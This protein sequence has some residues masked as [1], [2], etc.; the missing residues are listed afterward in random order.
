MQSVS[1]QRIGKHATTTIEVLLESVFYIP[2]VQNGHKED[3]VIHLVKAVQLSPASEAEKR[4][5]CS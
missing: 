5:R 2:S 3:R 1:K 4:W